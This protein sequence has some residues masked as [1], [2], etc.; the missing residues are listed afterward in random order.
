MH[1]KAEGV[2]T[3]VPGQYG[4]MVVRRIIVRTLLALAA[5]LAIPALLWVVGVHGMAFVAVELV[6][7]ATMLLGDRHISP[8]LDRRIRGNAGETL[9]GAILDSLRQ[10]GWM[11]LHDVQTG[12][13]N[14]DHIAIG[15][16]G[17]LTVETKSHRGRIVAANVKPQWL[18]QAYAQRKYVEAVID[19]KVDCLLVFSQA[20]LDRAPS[21]QRGVLLLPARMLAGH[22]ARRSV[23]LTPERV[24][25]LQEALVAHFDGPLLTQSS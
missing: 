22:L 24:A 10:D 11:T 2:A 8:I 1:A 6:V 14:I 25:E 17:V 12:H 19:S 3:R 7:I 13:G 16:G 18:G 23:L 5:L 21:R 9:V 20:S 15:P 4:Q